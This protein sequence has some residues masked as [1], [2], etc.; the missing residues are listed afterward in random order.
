MVKNFLISISSIPVVGHAQP[1]IQWVLVALSKGVKQPRHEADHSP[2]TSAKVKKMWIYTFT[3]PTHIFTILYIPRDDDC[4][5]VDWEL[6]RLIGNK[7][8]DGF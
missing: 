4:F 1:P 8:Q 6:I 2:S 5:M 3:P 7:K